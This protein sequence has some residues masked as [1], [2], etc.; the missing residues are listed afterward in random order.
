[1]FFPVLLTVRSNRK[2]KCNP[3][4]DVAMKEQLAKE[5]PIAQRFLRRRLDPDLAQRL[6]QQGEFARELLDHLRS[7]SEPLLLFSPERL[8][9]IARLLEVYDPEEYSWEQEIADNAVDGKVYGASNAYCRRFLELPDDFDFTEHPHPDPQ[10][11][12][13]IC[14][15]RWYGSLARQYW[16]RQESRYFEALM[17]HWDFF[18]RQA[19]CPENEEDLL[20]A[21]H[22]IGRPSPP[23]PWW[24]LDCYI[25]LKNW[26]W[27]FWLSLYAEE[28]TPQRQAV[29]LARCLRLFD[30]VAARGIGQQEHNFTSMQMESLYLWAA[31][32]PEFTGMRVWR[33]AARA[34]LESSLS[35]AVFKDGVQW[36]KSAGYHRGCMRWYGTPLVLGRRINDLWPDEYSE[37]LRRMTDYLDAIITPDGKTPLLSDSD[38]VGDWRSPMA[39]MRSLFP[40]LEL[41]HPVRPAYYSLWATDGTVWPEQDAKPW[42]H[43]RIFPVGGVGVL[44][45]PDGMLILDNGPTNAGHSHFDNLTLHYEALGRPILVDPGR[46]IYRGDADRDWVIKPQ[47]HNLVMPEDRM[48]GPDDRGNDPVLLPVSPEDARLD[49]IHS[50]HGDSHIGLGTACRAYAGDPTAC[51]ERTVAVGRH[52]GAPWLLVVDRVRAA[53]RHTWT[54]NWLFPTDKSA[55]MEDGELVIG[56]DEEV[57]VRVLYIGELSLRDELRFWCPNYA[58]QD[59]ARWLRFTGEPVHEEVRAFAFLPRLGAGGRTP[60]LN[61]DGEDVTL[62]WEELL[63]R[64]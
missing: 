7:R 24:Q 43:T 50:A 4:N 19:P 52:E 3:E 6:A 48:I 22:G 8:P 59:P 34:N 13:G 14:R 5:Y 62:E 12:H 51:A 1:L 38:R 20:G 42:P 54:N 60:S 28:M 58:E 33:N 36:E 18:A 26:Y 55:R 35:R 16:R 44:R 39:L 61:L 27:A 56:L 37:R 41:C 45:W 32:L 25:R 53:R 17:E 21:Y 9:E 31:A 64:L 23:P 15:H 30:A 57:S 46:H 47:S 2:R 11:I 40:D 49:P 63:V 10:T 29:L